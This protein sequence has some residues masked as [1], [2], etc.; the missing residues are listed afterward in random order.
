LKLQPYLRAL[1]YL[2]VFICSVFTCSCT[3]PFGPG[4]TIDK[5]DVNVHFQS[6]PPPR[7]SIES[8][9]QLTNTGTQPL[10]ALELRLPGRRRFKSSNVDLT[11]DGQI[12]TAEQSPANARNTLLTLPRA[13][14]VSDRHSLHITM[15]FQTSVQGESYLDFAPDAFFLPA[16]SWAAELLPA[17]GIF[18]TGGVPPGKWNLTVHVPPGFAVHTSGDQIKTSKRSDEI[19][20]RAKQRAVDVYPYVI[21]GRYVTKQIGSE[22]QKIYLWTRKPQNAGDIRVVSDSLVKTLESYN[23][24]FGGRAGEGGSRGYFGKLSSAHANV[25]RPFWL[26][27]CPVIPGC[28]TGRNL[29]NTRVVGND[30]EPKSG[31]MI[32][33]DTAMIDPSPGVTKTVAAA[34]PALAASWLGYGQSPGF[35]EQD[36]PLSAFPAFAAAVGGDALNGPA[37]RTETIRRALA[38]V[39]KDNSMLEEGD[40]SVLR[41][42]SFLFFYG[43]QDRYGHE[44]F[45]NALKH[46]LYARRSGGFNL[47]DL[48]A[49]FDQELHGNAAEF[50]RLWMKHPGVPADFRARYENAPANKTV[51]SKETTP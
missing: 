28:F 3:A 39:P 44:V 25:E 33:L 22:H 38:A 5:Q 8:T 49:A 11:W 50:V 35:Y 15:T 21:A 51:S 1:L 26:V 31:E 2:F 27:E 30:N 6:G 7:I 4:Y 29:T 34:A 41:A 14:T 43:L 18:A 16:Q 36:P 45:R 19:T 32:S 23:S 10:S 46:M 17:R 9:Y 12:L 40:N 20:I 48:I 13:W 42:K 47:D 24:V 37:A